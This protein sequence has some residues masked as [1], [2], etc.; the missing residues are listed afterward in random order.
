MPLW[1]QLIRLQTADWRRLLRTFLLKARALVSSSGRGVVAVP[2]L[3]LR[4]GIIHEG[5]ELA[6]LPEFHPVLEALP[7]VSGL[8]DPRCRLKDD[9]H[10]HWRPL[11]VPGAGLNA[12]ELGGEDVHK[13]VAHFSFWDRIVGHGENHNPPPPPLPCG[14]PAHAAV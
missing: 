4:L 6:P 5:S 13:V 1:S 9:S 3:H 10:K 8:L 11:G 14:I 7:D 12:A 2:A